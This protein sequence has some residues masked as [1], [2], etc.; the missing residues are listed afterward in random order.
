MKVINLILASSILI[1]TNMLNSPAIAQ[2]KLFKMT[3]VKSG[4]VF[5]EESNVSISRQLFKSIMYMI[6]DTVTIT[7]DL[8]S[9]GQRFSQLDLAFGISDGERCRSSQF[10]SLYLDGKNVGNFELNSGILKTT[11]L[12]IAGK[13]SFFLAFQGANCAASGAVHFVNATLR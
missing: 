1:L 11:R 10:V 8:T 13:R 9:S 6:Y 2:T 3:C 12:N 4:R 7:C 5:F